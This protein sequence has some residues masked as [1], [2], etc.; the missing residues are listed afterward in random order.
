VAVRDGVERA[1]INSDK[2]GH[3]LGQGEV[4]V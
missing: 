3:R 1:R 4:S 2:L